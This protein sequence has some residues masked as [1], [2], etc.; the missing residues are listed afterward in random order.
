MPESLIE[1][2]AR[3]EK[4]QKIIDNAIEGARNSSHD[5]RY[6]PLAEMLRTRDALVARIAALDSSQKKTGS[7]IRMVQ[8]NYDPGIW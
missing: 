7:S 5:V 4:L 6:R 3:R 1:L 8:L 2:E